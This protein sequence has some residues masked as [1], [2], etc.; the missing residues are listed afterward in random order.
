MTKFKAILLWPWVYVLDFC[1]ALTCAL[2]FKQA[3]AESREK[4]AAILNRNNQAARSS[5]DT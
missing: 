5:V 2:T 1:I 4:F 3:R